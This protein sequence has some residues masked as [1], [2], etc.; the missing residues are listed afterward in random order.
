[1]PESPEVA[2]DL[3]LE[4]PFYELLRLEVDRDDSNFESV[5]ELIETWVWV[6]LTRYHDRFGA[7]VES[8]INVSDETVDR[9]MLRAE[10]ARQRGKDPQFAW[11]DVVSD[12]VQVDPVILDEAGDEVRPDWLE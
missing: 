6:Q 11:W 9:M 4:R 1:M 12:F 10:F 5:D 7:R 3:S 2:V 8:P